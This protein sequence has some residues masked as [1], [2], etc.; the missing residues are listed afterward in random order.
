[1]SGRI[2]CSKE[3]RTMITRLA[4]RDTIIHSIYLEC[5]FINGNGGYPQSVQHVLENQEE[6]DKSIVRDALNIFEEKLDKILR[7]YKNDILN[8]IMR[9]I[10]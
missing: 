7:L 9:N 8:K 1:M 6:Y 3:I 10:S 4:L 2:E 5:P